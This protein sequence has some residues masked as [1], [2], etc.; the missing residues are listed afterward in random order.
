MTRR[1]LVRL[2]LPL[3]VAAGSACIVP[4]Y[5]QESPP[6][7][8]AAEP[9][10]PPM[11]GDVSFFYDSLSPYGS[12]VYTAEYGWVWAPRVAV[13]WRPY[14]EGRWAW[15]DDGWTWVGAEAWAWGPYHYGRWFWR[16]GYGWAWV[17]GSV[18]APAWVAWRSGG[19]HLGWAPLPPSVRWEAGI[20]FSGGGV[21]FGAAIAPEH[22]CFVEERYITAPT[23]REYVVPPARNVTFVHVTNNITNYT[24]VENRVVN[25]S[26]DTRRVEEATGQRVVRYRIVDRESPAALQAQG[27]GQGEIPMVRRVGPPSALSVTAGPPAA[28]SHPTSVGTPPAHGPATGPPFVRT[29]VPATAKVESVEEINR[30]HELEMQ[31]LRSHQDAERIRL[32]QI[33]ATEG[34]QSTTGATADQVTAQHQAEVKLLD[35]QHRDEAE[36]LARRHQKEI[37]A[38][39]KT[40]AKAKPTPKPT[41]KARYHRDDDKNPR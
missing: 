27:L 12:W 25:R 14:T 23:I 17:P 1:I 26:I 3:A 39:A 40:K 41:P 5:E 37:E 31:A 4:V 7:A 33:H 21:D 2:V 8:P 18:W 13:W 28:G 19:G 15:T 24:E 36:L 30:R 9:A 32:Q 11:S 29:P 22:W 34:V 16:G 6:P 10:P 35:V 38:T 20:G